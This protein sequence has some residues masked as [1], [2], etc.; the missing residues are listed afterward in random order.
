[1][2]FVEEDHN[3]L[4][5]VIVLG[6]V[7]CEGPKQWQDFLPID[8]VNPADRN[9]WVLFADKLGV[10]GDLYYFVTNG[11]EWEYVIAQDGLDDEYLFMNAE[12]LAEDVQS[13]KFIAIEVTPDQNLTTKDKDFIGTCLRNWI[14]TG[15]RTYR[16]RNGT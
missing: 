2:Q 4:T 10:A 5:C 9:I 8:G 7:K 6:L 3:T 11:K 16:V 12:I 1:M 14:D 13:A 15:H